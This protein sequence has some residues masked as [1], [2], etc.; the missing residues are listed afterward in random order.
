MSQRDE[1]K[2]EV[3]RLLEYDEQYTHDSDGTK[4]FDYG[5]GADRIVADFDRLAGLLGYV[6]A[7]SE[8]WAVQYER[9]G[10]PTM[11]NPS[12]VVTNTTVV[13]GRSHAEQAVQN[14]APISAQNRRVVHRH[15]T[16]WEVA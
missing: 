12:G 4:W 16:E 9:K 6:K 2:A 11:S 15:V 13:S 3:A 8:E 1:A 14:R 7:D 10:D 5:S